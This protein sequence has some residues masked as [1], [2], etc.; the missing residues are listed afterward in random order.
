MHARSP[1]MQARVLGKRAEE[2]AGA[3]GHL[4]LLSYTGAL[5][6]RLG[7]S[8][9]QTWPSKDAWRYVFQDKKI[10]NILFISW[11]V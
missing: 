5:N 4:F 7:E 10:E 3:M 11:L 2:W 1:I 8:H 6:P 9:I